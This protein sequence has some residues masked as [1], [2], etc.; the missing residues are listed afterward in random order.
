MET[1]NLPLLPVEQEKSKWNALL[2]TISSGLLFIAADYL[3]FKSWEAVFL[4]VAV[5][6]I[7]ELGHFIAMKLYGYKGIQLTFVPF[8]GAYVSGE[9][10][11]FSRHK[12]IIMLLAGPLP[13]ILIGTVLYFVYLEHPQT[14]Y[15]WAAFSFLALNFFNLIPISPLDGGQIVET[16]FFSAS[17]I[18][19]TC[20][21]LF[22]LFV[23]IY[24]AIH[25]KW[26]V[27]LLIA[28]PIAF[29]IYAIHIRYIVRKALA[30]AGV[31]YH[32]NFDDLEDEQYWQI[33]DVLVTKNKLLSR[34]YKAGEHSANE[35][36]LISPVKDILSPYYD[37]SLTLQQKAA[38]VVVWLIAFL[39]PLIIAWDYKW[40]SIF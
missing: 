20:F 12:K 38:F 6:L 36:E 3:L 25:F 1:D 7:H 23:I 27:L 22:S 28:I 21:L 11:D 35:S 37:Q 15:F 16:L 30:I 8:I 29:R 2:R 18:L 19:Q 40:A 39:I 14:A 9:A 26:W 33:R 5:I 4:L 24:C 32:C 17:R 34:R 31:D 13:G 10:A